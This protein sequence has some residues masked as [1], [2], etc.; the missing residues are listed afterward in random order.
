MTQL[1]NKTHNRQ[2]EDMTTVHVQRLSKV[3]VQA[4][5]SQHFSRDFR[6]VRVV[7][8]DPSNGRPMMQCLLLIPISRQKHPSFRQVHYGLQTGSKLSSDDK[9]ILFCMA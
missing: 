3:G 5:K 7:I 2:A 1:Y 8:I 9:S 6:G 4:H